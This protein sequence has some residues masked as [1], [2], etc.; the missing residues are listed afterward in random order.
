MRR[1]LL[2]ENVIAGFGKVS[3]A[4]MNDGECVATRAVCDC[5]R[6]TKCRDGASGDGQNMTGSSCLP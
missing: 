6:P 2:P 5:G 1:F 3:D 4:R